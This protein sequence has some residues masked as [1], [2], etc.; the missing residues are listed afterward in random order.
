[1]LSKLI[2]TIRMVKLLGILDKG[3]AGM[4]IERGGVAGAND[5][6]SYR[7]VTLTILIYWLV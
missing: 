4:D 7:G 2:L 6:Q 3:P 1:M 5:G